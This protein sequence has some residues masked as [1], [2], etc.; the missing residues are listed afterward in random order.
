MPESAKPGSAHDGVGVVKNADTKGGT[1][2]LEHEPIPSINWSAMT[3]TFATADKK[4]L[5]KVKPGDKVHFQLKE[6]D[7][8][9]GTYV[10]TSIK[11]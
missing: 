2:T 10:V 8:K 4:M 3:M 11:E 6:S 7:S 5:E 1:I 9:K